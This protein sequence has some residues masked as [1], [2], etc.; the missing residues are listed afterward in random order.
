[1]GAMKSVLMDIC[2]G[3]TLAGRNLVDSA[4]KQDP[5]FM[6][7]VLVNILANLPSYLTALRGE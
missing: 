1:M 3:M 2:D 4:E 5:E 7:A 6:E